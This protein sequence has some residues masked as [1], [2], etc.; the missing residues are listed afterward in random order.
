VLRN[1]ADLLVHNKVCT[2]VGFAQ[3]GD[4]TVADYLYYALQYDMRA[5]DVAAE[6]QDQTMENLLE[7][8]SAVEI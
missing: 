8:Q 2:V 5:V 1:N 7:R 4:G 6:V 3:N